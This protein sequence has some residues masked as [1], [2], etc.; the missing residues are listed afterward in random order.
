M[1]ISCI[2]H[3]EVVACPD[4]RFD[5]IS[6]LSSTNTTLEIRFTFT[7]GM[8]GRLC[9]APTA[10]PTSVQYTSPELSSI[11]GTTGNPH[12]QTLV[13]LTPDTEYLVT[14]QTTADGGSTWENISCPTSFT[15]P[16]DIHTFPP[17][18]V[19]ASAPEYISPVALPTVDNA[20]VVDPNTGVTLRRLIGGVRHEYSERRAVNQGKSRYLSNAS[21]LYDFNT[22]ALTNDLGAAPVSMSS[23]IVFSMT[24]PDVVFGFSFGELKAYNF[25]TNTLVSTGITG[26]GF[27]PFE[28]GPSIND[29]VIITDNLGTMK[30]VDM[31]NINNAVVLATQAEPANR[32]ALHVSPDGNYVVVAYPGGATIYNN[33]LQAQRTIPFGGHG[34]TASRA[35]GS[36]V[37]AVT[38]NAGDIRVYTL[39]DNSGA[40][41]YD[42]GFINIS[43]ASHF[44]GQAAGRPG[45]LYGSFNTDF[46]NA[47][48]DTTSGFIGTVDLEPNSRTHEVWTSYWFQ[49]HVYE[50][51]PKASPTKDGR[52]VVFT[53]PVGGGGATDYVVTC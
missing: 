25:I 14:S 49:N 37:Y 23:E 6:L 50:N 32:D 12:V 36:Q 42:L 39:S 48:G 17:S 4:S 47:D 8:P 16:L 31:S 2:N 3:P 45:K 9:Y 34:A 52:A 28:T 43:G 19:S 26:F 51:T 29:R 1:A 33:L 44:S 38:D 27:G 11:Y 10:S 41:D 30:L 35:N 18:V 13:N 46:N 21:A 7:A 24:N 40:S 22:L 15:T 20:S 53:T 5:G